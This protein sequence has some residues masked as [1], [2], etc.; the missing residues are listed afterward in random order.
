MSSVLGVDEGFV[1]D[2]LSGPLLGFLCPCRRSGRMKEREEVG[3]T[4]RRVARS[5]PNTI[6]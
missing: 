6:S 5:R 1:E 4:Q 2:S 3:G